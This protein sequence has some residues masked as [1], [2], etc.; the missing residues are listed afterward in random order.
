M[1]QFADGGGL[2]GA[3]DADHQDHIGLDG[4]IDDQRLLD[5]LQ[6]LEHGVVQRLEQRVDVAEFLARD[7]AAQ[8]IENACR[9]LHA[10]IG[11]DQ[12]GL[13]LIQDLGIDL[14]PGS[15]S[16]MSVVSQAGPC[17]TWRAGA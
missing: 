12:P 10:H 4:R 7:A 6:D 15:S 14:A 16:L 5:R 3:V 13:E 2:A 11:G 17:S 8:V 9:R 1:R